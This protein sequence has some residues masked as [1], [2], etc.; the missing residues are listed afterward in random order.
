MSTEV[1]G[2]YDTIDAAN[3]A[4]QALEQAGFSAN[5]IVVETYR[6]NASGATTTAQESGWDKVLGKLHLI[7]P[8]HDA[9]YYSNGLRDGQTFVTVTTTDD[10]IQNA[11]DILNAN[12]ALDIETNIA[13]FYQKT[14][15]EYAPS[16]NLTATGLNAADD[17]TVIPVIEEELQVGKRQVQ[18]GGVRIYQHITERPVDEQISLH[19]ET[20]TVD[21]HAVDRPI[22]DADAAFAENILEVTETKEVPVVA[23]SARVVEEVVVGKTATDRVETVHDTVRR[24]DVNVE[25]IDGD[26]LEVDETQKVLR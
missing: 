2:L 17:N 10:R 26:D 20:V 4:A 16:A 11:A 22:T 21:R 13:E 8:K 1:L 6:A 15:A 9:A 23:K 12:G 19:E 24:T 7:A 18:R 3:Q 25:E 14:G 5:D